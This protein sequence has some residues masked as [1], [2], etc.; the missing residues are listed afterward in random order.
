MVSLVMS[1]WKTWKRSSEPSASGLRLN[2][3]FFRFCSLNCSLSTMRM[4]FASQVA[5]V[6]LER[7]GVH[8]DQHVGRVAGREDVAAGEVELEAA[9]AGQCARRGADLGG[10]IRQRAQIVAGQSGLVGEL[11]AGELH[12]VARVAGEA[13][14]DLIAFLDALQRAGPA[15]AA[16]ALSGSIMV[17]VLLSV[18]SPPH[19]VPRRRAPRGLRT[20]Y[21]GGLE[22]I[23]PR[24]PARVVRATRGARPAGTEA[25]RHG[26]PRTARQ[27]RQPGNPTAQQARQAWKPA[28]PPQACPD[29]AAPCA[30]TAVTEYSAGAP[31]CV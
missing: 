10:E 30:T 22:P 26:Y 15:A 17:S 5:D 27:T 13:D 24:V 28:R 23:Q 16:G 29:S 7:R 4:P 6:D 31:S 20:R 12:A 21:I 8:R 3:A 2:S 14:D 25:C 9:D 19:P 18:R 11:H 1:T